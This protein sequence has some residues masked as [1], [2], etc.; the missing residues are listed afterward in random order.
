MLENSPLAS[1]QALALV[2]QISKATQ[3]IK[4]DKI[5]TVFLHRFPWVYHKKINKILSVQ[6]QNAQ[7]LLLQATMVKTE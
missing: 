2:S 4:V 5:L 3:S 7:K 1:T 6:P